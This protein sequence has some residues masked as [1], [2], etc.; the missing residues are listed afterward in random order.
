MVRIFW[1]CNADELENLIN[2]TPDGGICHL[3]PKEYYLTRQ[4]VINGKRNITVCGEGATLV[5]KYLNNADYSESVN[6]LAIKNCKNVTL[7]NIVMDTDVPTNVTATVEAVFEGEKSAVLK[8]EDDFNMKGDEVLMAFNTIDSEGSPDYHM[9]Y[10]SRHPDPKIVT[11]I[12][13]EILLA[14]TYASAKYDYLGDNRFKVYFNSLSELKAGQRLCI[15]H[16]MYG[17]CAITLN[18]SDDTCLKNITMYS[19]PGFGVAVLPRCRNL[20]VD[21]LKIIPKE[22]RKNLFGGNCDGIHL[23]GLCGN[24]VMKNC[25]FDGLGD[26]AL[27]VHATAGTV[28]ELID[29]RTVR[30]GYCKKTPDGKL[31]KR[32]CEKGDIIKAYDPVSM[33]QTGSFKVVSFENGVLTFEGLSGD[34]KKGD[35]LQNMTYA[36]SL[37]IDNCVVKNTRARGFLIQTS[38]V[39]IKNCKFFGMSSNAVKAAPC[40]SYWYEVGPTENFYM[41][42]NVIEKC[43]FVNPSTPEIGILTNHSHELGDVW[44]LHKNIRIENNLIKRCNGNVVTVVG[45]DGVRVSYNTFEGRRNTETDPVRTVNCTEV[46]VENNENK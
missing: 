37:L 40:F 15:R 11:L 44:H 30:C 29:E 13:G 28:T 32:W 46:T 25:V 3:E 41:H 22:G 26:D 6:A 18:D 9:N 34:F 20:T 38:N 4:V 31:P 23:T 2:E 39:E 35:T 10:Y 45:T 21:G 12:L 1:K 17:P 16:T 7:Q 27:N 43:A 14:N 42:D 8:V 36:P 24:F 19:V 33:A 5:A